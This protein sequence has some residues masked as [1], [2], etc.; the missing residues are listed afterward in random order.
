MTRGSNR[1]YDRDYADPLEVPPEPIG[2]WGLSERSAPWARAEDAWGTGARA[3]EGEPDRR[4]STRRGGRMWGAPGYGWGAGRPYG[5]YERAPEDYGRRELG[6]RRRHRGLSRGE[7]DPA[8]L[9]Q[10]TGAWGPGQ[11]EPGLWGRGPERPRGRRPSY[12]RDLR[13]PSAGWAPGGEIGWRGWGYEWTGRPRARDERDWQ[14]RPAR[15]PSDEWGQYRTEPRAGAWS[16]G[17]QRGAMLRPTRE[18]GSGRERGRRSAAR[19]DLREGEAWNEIG[20]GRWTHERHP[21]D[22]EGFAKEWDRGFYFGLE[23]KGGGT[24]PSVGRHRWTPGTGRGPGGQEHIE[25]YGPPARRPVGWRP[26]GGAGRR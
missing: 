1:D 7:V 15:T 21:A 23:D 16:Y 22:R 2:F 11:A 9:H 8:T 18:P 12:D 5:A 6:W 17:R 25:D 14:G 4:D 19:P 24:P 10:G 26:G 3:R 13:E 20:P